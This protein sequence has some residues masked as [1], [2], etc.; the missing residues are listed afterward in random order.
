MSWRNVKLVFMREVRDQLRD[1]RTLFMITVLP[2]LL[3]PMMGLGI[4]E[5]MLTFSEQQR[6]VVILNADDLPESPALLDDQGIR[7]QWY[8]DGE[9]DTARLRILAER[10]EVAVPSD[11]AQNETA[12]ANDS[13][14]ATP[15]SGGTT[16]PATEPH[17]RPGEKSDAE[18]LT[19]AHELAKEIESLQV[20]R[21]MRS[22]NPD[23]PAGGVT[24]AGAR[25]ALQDLISELFGN[26]GFQVLVVVP[27]GYGAAMQL[28]NDQIKA[29]SEGSETDATPLAHVPPLLIIRNSAD[30]KSSV[31][32]ARVQRALANW[33]DGV[34]RKS[35]ENASLPIEL[36]H[37]AQL[38]YVEI[39]LQ[40]QVSASVWSKMFPALLV[41]MALTG[42]FYP[43]IDLGA[44]EKERG[45]METLLISPARRV[46]LVLGKFATIMLFS[47][48]TAILNLF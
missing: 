5:M 38:S 16:L 20:L 30:D 21:A 33:E 37:P 24:S 9:K 41:I 12:A 15:D 19:T 48:A 10:T 18:L 40:E 27:E 14:S 8:E 23:D 35:F 2:V 4:L 47:V 42:A 13:G 32:F 31:A 45:T 34:R 36:E 43:A 22:N 1:R 26:S 28:M 25:E 6:V 11:A 17:R 29:R 3:Y 39:A 7:Q 46:E 44:G